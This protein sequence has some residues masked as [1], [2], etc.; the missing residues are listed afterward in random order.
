MSRWLAV[1]GLL[2]LSGLLVLGRAD[3]APVGKTEV[4]RPARTEPLG[5][6][7]TRPVKFAGFDDPAMT[8]RQALNRLS[9]DYGLDFEVNE[10]AF[11]AEGLADVLD[12][13][14]AEKPL[15]K[16]ERVRL[17]RLLRTVLAR[18][19]V[20]TG[21]A[22]VLRGHSIELT[23]NQAVRRQ[24]WGMSTGPF[25][26]LVNSSFDKVPLEDALKVLADQAEYNVVL[27]NR[28]GDRGKTPVTARFANTPLDTAVGF[29]ADM[30]DLRTV[31]LDNV[32]YVTTRDNAALWEARLK[33][34][35][36]STADSP[37]PSGLRVG[38][39]VG[40]ALP[41]APSGM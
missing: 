13:P 26:P 5:V 4:A 1:G 29:L 6:Q 41:P 19:P 31:L 32:V 28:I 15:R 8:L 16:R 40:S 9:K 17:D 18:V 3:S 2:A 39:G 21:V 24:I 20:P 34:N 27:D 14:V 36:D 35:I 10:A 30:T 38:S 23:T 12:K 11:T 33:K 22:Y 37:E 25:L 7:L